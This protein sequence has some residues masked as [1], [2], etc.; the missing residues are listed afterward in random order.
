MFGHMVLEGAHRLSNTFKFWKIRTFV[1]NALPVVYD[2]CVLAVQTVLDV[3]T[4]T[5][6]LSYNL[7]GWFQGEG[8][9]RAL[10]PVSSTLPP[11]RGGT[12]GPG[13]SVTHLR[14]ESGPTE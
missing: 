6:H 11:A 12:A 3:M 2:V 8:T 13:W 4:V 1:L 7:A 14:V 10:F 9:D 5:C